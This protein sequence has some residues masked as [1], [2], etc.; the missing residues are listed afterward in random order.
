MRILFCNKYNFRFSGTEAYLFDTMELMRARGHEVALFSMT[1]ARGEETTYDRHF[2]SAVD[3][4]QSRN[5]SEK[6]R[7]AARAI[8]CLEAR[9]KIRGMIREFRPDVAHVRNIYHHL[10]PSIL[11]ELKKQRV[12]VVYHMNDMKLLCPTYNMVGASGG[13]CDKCKGGGFWHVMTEGCYGE[14]RGAATAL[15]MEAYVHR[16]MRTYKRCVDVFLTPSEFV[17]KMMVE[18]GWRNCD[19]RALPHCQEMPLTHAPYPGAEAPILYFGRLSREKGVADLIAAMSS[20]PDIRLIVAGEGPQRGDLER[21]ASALELKNISFAGQVTGAALA[22]LISSSQFTVFPSRAYE[23]LGKSILESFAHGR[24]VVAS[25]L[26][27]RRELLEDGA[28]G[29]LYQA[30]DVQEL[31]AAIRRLSNRPELARAMGEAARLLVREKHSAEQHLNA[32]TEIYEQLAAANLKKRRKLAFLPAESSQRLKIAYIGG[33]GLIGKYS[34]IETY[35]EETG[36]RLAARGHEVTVYCRSYFT[37]EPGTHDG[38]RIVRLPTIRSKHLETLVHTAL[39][40]L[41]ACFSQ[42]DIVHYHALGPALFSFVPRVFGKKTV[43]TVQGLDWQRKKW[44]WPARVALRAGG[45]AAARFPDRTVVV[46][47]TLQKYFQSKYGTETSYVPNGAQIRTRSCDDQLEQF[48]LA[49]QKYVL[50]LGRLSPEKNCDLLIESFES[51]G[52]EVDRE[53]K[54]V[55]AGGSGNTSEYVNRLR[56]RANE[57]IVFLDWLSGETLEQVLTH[58]ALFVLPSDLEGMSLSLLEAMGAGLCVLASDVPENREV[59]ADCGFTFKAGDVSDLRRAM[60]L[61]LNNDRLR[62]ISGQKARARVEQNYLWEQV[63]TEIETVYRDLA[64]RAVPEL[65]TAQ[66]PARK[67]A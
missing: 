53:F 54:L 63:T 15:A 17:R 62:E 16:W 20:L 51:L 44:S 38:M 64:P 33:R 7:L 21:L 41:H 25:D 26:G 5:L 19:I 37:P 46:S 31:A 9:R 47:R 18:N 39:S 40:T 42:S 49:A 48:G 10:T 22:T 27:S 61:L 29:L 56:R 3:F 2:V 28:T 45:W 30:G 35:Y 67:S 6:A 34:G 13:L 43:V 1:D 65:V 59:I 24:P 11:W 60:A 52:K 50:F 4:K 23:T 58:A 66:E 8:Y 14:S 32:L 36:K 12:P 55:L 57:R